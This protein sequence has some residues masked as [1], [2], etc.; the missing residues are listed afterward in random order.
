MRVN[1]GAPEIGLTQLKENHR[2]PTALAL[3]EVHRKL[4]WR[5]PRLLSQVVKTAPLSCGAA[6]AGGDHDAIPTGILGRILP[7]GKTRKN[8]GRDPAPDVGHPEP[9]RHGINPAFQNPRGEKSR[10]GGRRGQIGIDV[11]RDVQ[12]FGA[13]GVNEGEGLRDFPPVGPAGRLD[14]THL[15]GNPRFLT[16]PDRFLDR[17]EEVY[18]LAADVA[19]VEAAALSGDPSQRDELIGLGVAPRGVDEAGG[20]SPGPVLEAPRRQALHLGQFLSRRGP[21][22]KSH[23]CDPDRTVPDKLE[24]IHR[25]A[26]SLEPPEVVAERL[27]VP[28]EPSSQEAG[29]ALKLCVELRRK[30]S[31]GKPAIPDDLRGH[32]LADFRLGP[33]IGPEPEVRVGVH[34]NEAGGDDKAVG[35]EVNAG[36]L[37][38]ES[39]DR[40]DP[41]I[42]NSEVCGA[43]GFSAAVND[44]PPLYDQLEHNGS[45]SFV[46]ARELEVK[47][48]PQLT[49]ILW[50]MLI[51]PTRYS[52]F[53]YDSAGVKA[54]DSPDTLV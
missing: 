1:E 38:T 18:A 15:D 49:H 4:D 5:L 21:A 46:P 27:P 30:R 54:I 34:V 28:V 8:L 29:E 42:P 32:A 7:A 48:Y 23:R 44:P 51:S 19:C 37:A 31:G 40:R 16:D 33:A 24:D 13:G 47:S 12:P 10:E 43:G 6:R 36:R 45:A 17:A 22:G 3:E 11:S 53:S 52:S 25:R 9:R 35:P 20:E 41:V 39:A 26:V 14:V 2:D 50:I